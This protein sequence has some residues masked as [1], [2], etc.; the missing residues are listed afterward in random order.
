MEVTVLHSRA[1]LLSRSRAAHVALLALPFVVVVI[2]FRGLSH[3][4]PVYQA[5]DEIVHAQ[6]VASVAHIWPRPILSGYYA[7]SGPFVYWLLATLALP[8]GASLM[9]VRLVV[10]TLSWATCV[11]A[12]V[13]L[14]DRLGA[15]PRIAFAFALMLAVSAFFFGESFRVLTDNPTWLFVALALERVLAF[16]QDPRTGRLMAFALFAAAATTMRQVSVWLFLPGML[17][18]L[19]APLSARRRL[20]DLGILALGLMPLVAVLAYWGGPLPPGTGGAITYDGVARLRNLLLSLAVTG[21]YGG[22]LLPAAE[23]RATPLRLGRRGVVAI[24]SAVGASLIALGLHVMLS[25][26]GAQTLGMGLLARSSVWYPAL[27]GTSVI[28]WLLVP[29]GAA[30]VAY[31]LYA[32]TSRPTDRVL[33]TALVAVLLS[34][35]LNATWYQ[36]YV[37]FPILL[38]L[39]ALAVSAH[40]EFHFLDRFRWVIVVALSLAWTMLFALAYFLPN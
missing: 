31:L 27:E 15:P 32:R 29:L 1:A 39:A 34:A 6:I 9:V 23:L 28:W 14:R 7:W 35:A 17:A 10:A 21:L 20:A 30:V 8:F 25:L 4:F 11:T 26:P 3:G 13:I 40:V 16:S 12:Y 5:G 24:V 22:L 19:S 18:V 33:V 38:I 36:R 2:A 37:D